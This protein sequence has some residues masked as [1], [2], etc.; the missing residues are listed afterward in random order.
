MFLETDRLL[1][2]DFKEDDWPALHAVESLPEVAQYQD[3][4]PRMEAESREYVRGAV[5]DAAAEPRRTYDLAVIL[6]REGRLIRRC[7]L[8]IDDSESREAILWYTLHPSYWG[9]GYT[10]E[11]ARSLV[12]F[13]FRELRLHRIWADCDPANIGSWRVLEKLGMRREGHLV[14]NAWI[15]GAWVDSLIY[16]ILER[17]WVALTPNPSPIPMGEGSLT[18]G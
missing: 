9:K 3:F 10:T 13:G 4:V 7:G 1:L 14:E 2:R 8:G 18:S 17:E 15:K 11:A 12:D 6:Q 16:A 5:E